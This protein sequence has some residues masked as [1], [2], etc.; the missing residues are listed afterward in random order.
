MIMKSRED[1]ESA[2]DV[3]II[4]AVSQGRDNV[5][6]MPLLPWETPSISVSDCFDCS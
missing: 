1:S 5:N 4:L 6:E 3:K 2:K